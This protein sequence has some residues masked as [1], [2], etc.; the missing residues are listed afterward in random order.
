MDKVLEIG[1]VQ[2]TARDIKNQKR[3][4]VLTGG[5]FDILHIGHIK[6]LQSAK[7]QADCLIVL[8]ESD[9][10]TKKIKGESRPINNQDVRAEILSALTCVDYVIKLPAM[11][12]DS[13]YDKLVTQIEPDIIAV[14]ENDKNL[15]HKKRQAE[16]LGTRLLEVTPEISNQSTT[17]LIK[18]LEKEL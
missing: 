10:T 1:Q 16:F 13:D 18:I 4:I 15:K 14:S 5:I 7:E 6:F 12:N 11:K 8:L 9:E 3:S 17:R 2:K